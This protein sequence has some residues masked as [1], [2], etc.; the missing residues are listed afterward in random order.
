MNKKAGF[1]KKFYFDGEDTGIIGS[2]S[3][4]FGLLLIATILSYKTIFAA[5]FDFIYNDSGIGNAQTAVILMFAVFLIVFVAIPSV[6]LISEIVNG[7]REKRWYLVFMLV[8]LLLIYS[9][10]LVFQFVHSYFD[11]AGEA[12]SVIS[13]S[14]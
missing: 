14:R 7:I 13:Q 4:F 1:L 6:P 9:V 2:Y 11:F 12:L 3:S 8:F 5:G 10:A